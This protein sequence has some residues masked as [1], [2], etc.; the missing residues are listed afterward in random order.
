MVDEFQCSRLLV[1]QRSAAAV[2]SGLMTRSR[3]RRMIG[4]GDGDG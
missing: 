2:L 4:V 1:V 3:R